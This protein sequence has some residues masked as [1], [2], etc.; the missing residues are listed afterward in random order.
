MDWINETESETGLIE[1]PEKFLIPEE[2]PETLTCAEQEQIVAQNRDTLYKMSAAIAIVL[3]I[4]TAALIIAF[5]INEDFFDASSRFGLL[6]KSA[7]AQEENEAYP[8]INVKAEFDDSGEAKLVI[9]LGMLDPGDDI[10]VREEFTKNKLIIK[11]EG[12]SEYISDGIRLTSDSQIM[13]AVG[14][15]R[16]NLDVFVEVYCR[17]TY[18]YILSNTGRNLT[19]SFFPLRTNYDAVAVVYLPYEDRNR[20]AL[21]EWQQSIT[22]FASENRI[23][24]FMASNMQEPYTQQEIIEFAK[25][26]DADIVLGLEVSTDADSS[27][28]MG[29]AIC[30]T[31]YFMPD[32]NS[33]QLSVVFAEAFLSE[34]QFKISGFAE[35]D[36]STPLVYRATC[37]AAMIKISQ[38]Q[39][40]ADSVEAVYKLNE[41]LVATLTHTLG[42]IYLPQQ[43]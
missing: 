12:A 32:F 37:P 35:A 31:T 6:M 9:P 22:K 25:K 4:A 43:Q 29:T 30:N 7:N 11:L 16:Q 19:V 36:E 15:Y 40:D 27:Q 14:I 38:S 1:A 17:D 20:F 26:I 10:V 13:D 5:K 8:K 33:A 18:S 2:E 23:R 39:K 24:L 41:K 42:D 3:F 28:T 21:P 34:T